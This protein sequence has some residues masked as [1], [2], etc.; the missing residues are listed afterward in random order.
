MLR[1]N[2]SFHCS[3]WNLLLASDYW[4]LEILKKGSCSAEDFALSLQ[5]HLLNH[6]VCLPLSCF[7]NC[8]LSCK[9]HCWL[10]FYPSEDFKGSNVDSSLQIDYLD[11]NFYY[12]SENSCWPRDYCLFHSLKRFKKLLI[13]ATWNPCSNS[14]PGLFIVEFCSEH[15]PK[16][17]KVFVLHFLFLLFVFHL[18]FC[19]II[20]FKNFK[21]PL[22]SYY[23]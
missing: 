1:W 10:F 15:L 14:W 6:S 5:V 19:P 9:L 3:F 8:S 2:C 17:L 18:F 22:N 16:I 4:L 20:Y 11:Q 7:I 23:L 12:W 21:T 13:P